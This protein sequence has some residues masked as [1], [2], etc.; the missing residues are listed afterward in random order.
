MI[1]FLTLVGGS[2]FLLG[3]GHTL[4]YKLFMFSFYEETANG[5]TM[6][7]SVVPFIL[8]ITVSYIVGN[9]YEKKRQRNRYRAHSN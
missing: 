8:A 7:G 5:V 2:T 9:A 1:G 4:E 3:I 6:G